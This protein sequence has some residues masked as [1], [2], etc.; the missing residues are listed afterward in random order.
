MLTT[1][2]V[3]GKGRYR[4]IGNFTQDGTGSLYEAYD[5][6]SNT[7]VVLRE[8]TGTAGG[9]M[10]PAQL[11]EIN[12]TFAGEAKTLTEVRHESL[13]SVHDYFS[14]IDR[15][16]LVMESVNGCDLS[17]FLQPDEKMPAMADVM[18]WAD[19]VLAAIDY[20]H[21]LQHPI[22]HRDITP[23]NVRLTSNFKVKV[24]TAGIGDNDVIMASAGNP[25]DAAVLNYRPL[26]QLWGGLD[27][28]S[29]KVITNSYDDRSRRILQRPLDARSDVYSVGAT[30][31]HVLTRTMPK[32]ALE[33]SIEIL[34]GNMD[35]LTAPAELDPS[36]PEEVSEVIMKAM[37]LRREH[38]YDSAAIMR[39]V[40]VTGQQRAKARKSAEPKPRV[41][42][43]PVAD[44]TVALN[45][46]AKVA[47]PVQAA[48]VTVPTKA[49]SDAQEQRRAELRRL[50]IEADAERQ[51]NEAERIKAAEQVVRSRAKPNEPQT[52]DEDFLLEV[53]PVKTAGDEFEWSVDVSEQPS[54]G[55][56][57]KVATSE[58]SDD[59]EF[60]I[61]TA[62]TSNVKFIAAGAGGL[63]VLVAI[64][65]WFLIGGS[66]GNSSQKAEATTQQNSQQVQAP[67]STYSDA[68]TATP[69]T[70]Q[71][72]QISETVTV[73]GHT[74]N[75]SATKK[76]PT[77]TPAKTPDKKKVT[78]DDLINDN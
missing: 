44:P 78:V 36:I 61:A 49:E 71:V 21:T 52:T 50:E 42:P 16:Y 51:R 59:F 14:E 23:T 48:E 45:E 32:D 40:L 12:N 26:E 29:Q 27:P 53:E 24:L 73:D 25:A 75:Q 70:E 69:T 62:P 64:L 34:D 28:A 11:D 38:R 22:I 39:Q 58:N 77:P 17:K 2:Q 35:P 31:Y 67:V 8:S 30:F 13:L 10:T 37:E 41:A 6:V 18:K 54:G 19:Q 15:H 43:Q 66:P 68:N 65:G 7:N 57:Q 47:V 9:I 55:N 33:R 72:P 1:D 74:D 63:V 5:T 46:K 60:N 3:L 4:I 56:S 20:L 76:K